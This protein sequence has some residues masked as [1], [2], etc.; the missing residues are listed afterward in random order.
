MGLGREDHA[1]GILLGTI[2]LRVV[3]MT[4]CGWDRE[5]CYEFV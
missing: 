5:S 3:Y 1:I 4:M 2:M